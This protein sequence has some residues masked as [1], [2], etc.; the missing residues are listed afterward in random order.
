MVAMFGCA[1]ASAASSHLAVIHGDTPSF[2]VGGLAAPEKGWAL[3][4][5]LLINADFSQGLKGWNADPKCFSVANGTLE[6]NDA[7]KCSKLYPIAYNDYRVPPGSY[8]IKGDIRTLRVQAPQRIHGVRI[9][10]F[11]A[12]ATQLLE[13]TTPWTTVE[14]KDVV[15]PE[16]KSLLFR[17]E[18]YAK[19]SGIAWF[20]NLALYRNESPPLSVFMLYPNYRGLMFSDRSQ[21][22]VFYLRIRDSKA[23]YVALEV[24]GKVAQEIPARDRMQAK[25][26]LAQL[27]D[28]PH[29]VTV[30]LLDSAHRT[31]FAQS[32]YR[33]VKMPAAMRSKMKAWID[34]N[35]EAHFLDGKAH[36]VLGI[37][38]TT[39][40][41]P[42]ES[43]WGPRLASIARAP[44]NMIINYFIT[45]API[46]A[47]DAYTQAMAR[48]G[49]VFLPTV[50]NFHTSDK[51]YPSNLAASLWAK[52]QDQLI[53][54]Y[55]AALAS[56]PGV[57]GYYTQDEPQTTL[58]N[59]TFHQYQLIRENDPGGFALAVL[60]IPAAFSY[61]RDSVDVL[62][63]D[64]YPL[65]KSQ[66]NNLAEVA[67]WTRQAAAAVHGARPVWTVIQFFQA[68]SISA[69]PTEQQLHDMSWMAIT[70]GAEGLFYWSY[71]VRGLQWVKDW[72]WAPSHRYYPNQLV[73]DP[74]GNIERVLDAG[75]SGSTQPAWAKRLGAVT[76]DGAV[77]WQVAAVDR[78]MKDFLYDE[79]INV[80]KSIKTLEPVILSPDTVI[81]ASNSAETKVLTKQKSVGGVR[82]LF[83]CNDSGASVRA[84]FTLSAPASSV[85]VND[86]NRSV[87]LSLRS[88][89]DSFAPY[90]AHV[91][92][93]K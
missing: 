60:N 58:R 92:R 45:N 80:T 50:V 13:G 6:L 61:W 18:P 24:D 54:K 47:I 40:Y 74:N 76:A 26:S 7:A 9:D 85:S 55:A 23:S 8:T 31:L 17:I 25:I 48:H 11:G 43:Y 12:G 66:G 20:R 16:G 52:T 86:E 27:P 51:F 41:S 69:W 29:T 73:R 71:G 14:A 67:D 44:I 63:T 79:L 37:Y 38:D 2:Q 70:A 32:P 3:S 42:S 75:V 78:P 28:G 82:Y 22:A 72:P 62:G 1:L 33:V 84:T 81:L 10:L 77:R 68:T 19:P 90:Q 83:A 88:F 53:S 39:G 91:Y 64:P 57:A 35:N 21:T 4:P 34:A 93:I 46:S 89:S 65:W 5:N 56:N 30:E 15:V 49:M 59:E 36:F 87:A